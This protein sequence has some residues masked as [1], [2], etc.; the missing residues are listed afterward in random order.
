MNESTA[1]ID[2][3]EIIPLGQSISPL[4]TKVKIKVFHLGLNRNRSYIDK[5]TAI[6][7]IQD[8]EYQNQEKTVLKK[9]AS[10]PKRLP[11]T[12]TQASR[13]A[14]ILF[15]ILFLLRECIFN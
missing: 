14:I 10:P 5:E 4:I 3:V 11:K 13:T 15:I 8:L 1:I 7:T 12:R 2:S 6:E 9:I